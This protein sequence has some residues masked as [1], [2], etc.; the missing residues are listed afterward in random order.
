MANIMIVPVVKYVM[1]YIRSVPFKFM[2]LRVWLTVDEEL[3]NQ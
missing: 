1:A 3:Y 2:C